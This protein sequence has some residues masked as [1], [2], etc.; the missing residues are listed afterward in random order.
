MFGRL[1]S[2]RAVGVR[3][4]AA[5]K[6]P[7]VALVAGPR[8]TGSPVRLQCKRPGLVIT[9]KGTGRR[10]CR[11]SWRTTNRAWWSRCGMSKA[12]QTSQRRW[13]WW[14]GV[15]AELAVDAEVRAT[16][17]SD[18]TTAERARFVARPR[19]VSTAAKSTPKASWPPSTAWSVA[20][21]GMSIA[22]PA[23]RRSAQS[24]RPCSRQPVDLTAAWTPGLWLVQP[25]AMPRSKSGPWEAASSG[26]SLASDAQSGGG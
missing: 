5:P 3:S 16:R 19:S 2:S 13:H 25:A 22:L 12:A 23:I 1:P 4:G 18:Q 15:T 26:R 9:A 20:C 8:G 24:V 11:R 10:A 6:G 17:I 14:S 21:T 7:A